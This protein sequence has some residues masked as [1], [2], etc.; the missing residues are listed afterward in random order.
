MVMLTP[1]ATRV[2]TL[3]IDNYD[4]YTYNIFQMLAEVNGVAPVVIKND[5]FDGDWTRAW[6]AFQQRVHALRAELELHAGDSDSS[7]GDDDVLVACNVVLSPGPGHPAEPRD[8]GMCAD[9]IRESTV[10]LF[11]VCLGH[12]GLA[13]VYGGD[14]VNAPEVMHGRTSRIIVGNQQQP[15][16]HS[17]LFAFVPSEFEVVRYHSLVVSPKT[18]PRELRVTART[19]DGV[20]MAL[21]HCAKPQFGVQFHP[22][23]SAARFG[24]QLFQNFRDITTRQPPS[25][26][27]LRPRNRRECSATTD[28]I[29]ESSAC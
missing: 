22:E 5:D 2:L 19:V 4:S 26:C 11:G 25:K 28:Q 27:A 23:A 24:Y 20:I 3:L 1:R 18:L 7:D 29:R 13:Q 8:F 12:Q 14:V 16:Q 17:A 6:A 21:E 10:P 9:A 15:Q